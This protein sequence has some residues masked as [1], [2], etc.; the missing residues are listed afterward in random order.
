MRV[1]KTIAAS[2]AERVSGPMLSSSGDSGKT[3]LVGHRP[4][5]VFSPNTPQ[6]AAGRRTEPPVS[7][8]IAN[9]HRPAATATAGP[10]LEPP[11]IL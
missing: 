10:L 8:P 4:T 6:N 11:G 9:A 5:V 3:P 7:E 2:A 1:P